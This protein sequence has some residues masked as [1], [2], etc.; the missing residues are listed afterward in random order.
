MNVQGF[1]ELEET[2]D[3]C[4][5]L[6]DAVVSVVFW[7]QRHI[8]SGDT[9]NKTS[10]L[11]EFLIELGEN[12][13]ELFI[14]DVFQ[15]FNSCDH[16]EDTLNLVQAVAELYLGLTPRTHI[17]ASGQGQCTMRTV[18]SNEPTWK[19]SRKL[20]QQPSITAAE[21]QYR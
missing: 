5:Q 17:H 9:E 15:G 4:T 14:G 2:F 12:R 19:V 13:Q 20:V 11:V 3:L 1:L 7:V 16:I 18:D 10:V 6:F 8:Q 21:V